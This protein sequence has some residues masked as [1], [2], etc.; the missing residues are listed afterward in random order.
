LHRRA[1]L[2]CFILGLQPKGESQKKEQE[3]PAHAHPQYSRKKSRLADSR[4][5]G[6]ST[7]AE[8]A[9]AAHSQCLRRIVTRLQLKEEIG[10][11]VLMVEAVGQIASGLQI[12]MS[13]DG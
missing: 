3:Q 1:R 13:Q 9:P 10:H 12:N 11:A 4:L 5:F 2:V 8:S 7:G 6:V